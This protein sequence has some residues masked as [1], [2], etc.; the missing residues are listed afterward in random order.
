MAKIMESQEGL[1]DQSAEAYRRASTFYKAANDSQ[2]ANIC[3]LKSASMYSIQ[4]SLSMLADEK[5]QKDEA[6]SMLKD[7]MRRDPIFHRSKERC[8][9]DNL[10]RIRY[11]TKSMHEFADHLFFFDSAEKLNLWELTMLGRIKDMTV[12]ND[13]QLS[14]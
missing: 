13:V 9:V 8:F 3:I 11:E 4:E 7:W 2:Q 5:M 1:M 6:K 10:I 14:P 12:A